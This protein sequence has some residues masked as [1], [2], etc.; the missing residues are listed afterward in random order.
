MGR[1]WRHCRRGL[2]G[3]AAELLP[4]DAMM[5][6]VGQGTLAI[7][8]RADDAEMLTLV[9]AVDDRETRLVSQ[10]ERAFLRRLGGGCRPPLGALA[11]ARGDTM[12]V[13]GFVSNAEA[14]EAFRAE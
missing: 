8:A 11:P 1:R 5:P 14:E 9:S 4:L 12:R 10:A 2:L 3:R 13:R 7:E 6:A